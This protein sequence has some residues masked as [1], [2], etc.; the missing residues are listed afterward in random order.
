M[1]TV[2]LITF[3]FSGLAILIS[4]CSILLSRRFY[5]RKRKELDDIRRRL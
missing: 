3:I 4:T 5:R 1:K 2:H